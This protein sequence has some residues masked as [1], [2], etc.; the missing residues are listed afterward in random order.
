MRVALFIAA[1]LT[2]MLPGRLTADPAAPASIRDS[3]I[4]NHPAPGEFDPQAYLAECT[5]LV[6]DWP[7]FLAAKADVERIARGGP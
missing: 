2:S 7:A 4:A 3:R 5:Q 1:G 6:A